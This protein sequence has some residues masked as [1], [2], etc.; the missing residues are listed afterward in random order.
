[1]GSTL[2]REALRGQVPKVLAAATRLA[3]NKRATLKE[4]HLIS[5]RLYGI[6]RTAK[7]QP[8]SIPEAEVAKLVQQF[9]ALRG[10]ILHSRLAVL[11][12]HHSS[13]HEAGKI[14]AAIKMLPVVSAAWK[15]QMHQKMH[16]VCESHISRLAKSAKEDIIKANQWVTKCLSSAPKLKAKWSKVIA[17]KLKKALKW[18][19][20]AEKKAAARERRE[21]ARERAREK[22]EER[23]LAAK[24]RKAKP[25]MKKCM[26]KVFRCQNRLGTAICGFGGKCRKKCCGTS[27]GSCGGYL[28]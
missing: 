1:L 23:R 26:K 11:K 8:G 22:K 4:R 20:A 15:A 5:G 14:R 7:N 16:G 24:A 18:Q 3:R 6:I 9:I 28:R 10:V 25:C 12:R 27:R 17:P 13:A 21:A 2:K 19:A